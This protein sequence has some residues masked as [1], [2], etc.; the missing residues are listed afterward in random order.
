MRTKTALSFLVTLTLGAL[1]GCAADTVEGSGALGSDEFSATAVGVAEKDL[2]IAFALE[3]DALIGSGDRT[4]R[5]RAFFPSSWYAKILDA[6]HDTS[7]GEALDNE[8]A[9]SDWRV[10]S[11]R[12][13]PC[14]PLGVTPS[15]SIEGACWPEVRLVWQPVLHDMR[16]H[17]RFSPAFADDRAVHALFD[18]PAEAGLTSTEAARARALK[19]AIQAYVAR[20]AGGAFQPLS[21]PDLAEFERLRNKV[22]SALVARARSLRSPARG[23]SEYVDHGIR[24]ESYGTSAEQ[25]DFKA[26]TI[27]FLSAYASPENIK[28]LTSFS[29]PEGRE[30]AHLDEWVFLA[31]RGQNGEI[32]PEDIVLR[33]SVDG[34]ELFNFGPSETGTMVTDDDRLYDAVDGSADG[35]EIAASVMLTGADVDRLTPVLSDRRQRLVP[36]TSCVS[37]HKMND[38][39]FDFHN[40]SYLE[41]RELTVSPRVITDV[42]LDLGW[43]SR[44]LDLR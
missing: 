8:N 30:P 16:V 31:F 11:L 23:Q 37:C 42:A 10:V 3:S 4:A 34:R 19:G 2:A 43:L 39:R 14:S 17:E 25:R 29:L 36:N 5:G 35:R 13:A 26:R 22:T 32:A 41:D 27:S 33:S 7:V 24:P 6:Y 40:L 15:M 9:L 44:K 12:V 38:L 1:S 28:A 21:S 20:G 18:A